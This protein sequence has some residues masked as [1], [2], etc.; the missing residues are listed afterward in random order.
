MWQFP[1]LEPIMGTSAG[2]A[3]GGTQRAKGGPGIWPSLGISPPPHA[4]GVWP[5]QTRQHLTL[6]GHLDSPVG[7]GAVLQ[8]CL[9]GVGVG[10]Q[11][12]VNNVQRLLLR[13]PA[14][15]VEEPGLWHGPV[16]VHILEEEEQCP[17]AGGIRRPCGAGG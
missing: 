1:S 15:D 16:V 11:V 8:S 3:W 5:S 14:A 9:E 13:L 12:L 10:G 7:T 2:C 6:S 17:R 4:K